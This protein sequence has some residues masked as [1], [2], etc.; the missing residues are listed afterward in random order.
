MEVL[1]ICWANVGRSQMAR[2]Y[3]NH[4]TG[5]QDADSAG[6][7]VEIPGETLGER[8]QRRGGTFTIEAMSKEGIDVN[9]NV[10]TQVTP[11]MLNGYDA[12]VCMAQEEH[13]PDWL[14]QSPKFIRWDV[15]DPG[16]KG[17]VETITARDAIK[18]K[19]LEFID[20][21]KA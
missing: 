8:K 19:V 15:E 11:K 14:T 21:T 16:G 12:V 1:F 9:G 20:L 18:S 10:M 7:E 17:L 5:T 6:T 2:S 4:I 13:T 3:Y